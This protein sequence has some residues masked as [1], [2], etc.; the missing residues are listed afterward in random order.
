MTAG[1]LDALEAAV[2]DALTAAL[3]AAL[4]RLAAAAGP[5]A[6]TVAQVADRLEVSEATIR[7]L[8]DAGRLLTVP[9]L[10]PKRIAVTA[11]DDFL[12]GK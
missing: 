10:N 4:D 5:R 9:Y 2:A 8:I 1:S 12:A 6:Y 3:P 7:R 11:L